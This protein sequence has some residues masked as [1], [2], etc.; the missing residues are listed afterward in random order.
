MK[1]MRPVLY[2]V[3]LIMVFGTG[4]YIGSRSEN[5]MPIS[6][7]NARKAVQTLWVKA[8][9]PPLPKVSIDGT[10]LKLQRGGYSWCN[11]DNCATTDAA[12]PRLKDMTPVAVQGGADIQ[13]KPPEGIQGFT[14]L[15]LTDSGN[16]GYTVPAKA[17]S[18]LYEIHCTWPLDQGEASFYFAV[19][20]E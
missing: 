12:R 4:Y 6:K 8:A 18:Y 5:V 11:G 20:V 9:E 17:G 1:K 2:I 19:T 13:S 16:D 3:L 10:E 14:L 15:N 7:E